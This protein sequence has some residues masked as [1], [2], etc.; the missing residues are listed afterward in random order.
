MW[1]MKKELEQ[2]L[3]FQAGRDWKQFHSPKNVAIS[4]A[5]EAAEVLEVF[6]WS[7][8]N[9]LPEDKIDHWPQD[10]VNM[11]GLCS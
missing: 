6:Q 8:D 9:S 5:L 7:K 11:G 2:I 4:L 3:K 1:F 10:K